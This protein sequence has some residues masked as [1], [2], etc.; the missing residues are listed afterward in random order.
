MIFN[1]HSIILAIEN[2]EVFEVRTQHCNFF[3]IIIQNGNKTIIL[4][5]KYGKAN[6]VGTLKK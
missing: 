1:T 4:Y 2:N 5:V 6:S 3:G